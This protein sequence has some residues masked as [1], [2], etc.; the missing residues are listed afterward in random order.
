MLWISI[1]LA[2]VVFLFF[3]AQLTLSSRMAADDFC[4]AEK[5]ADLGFLNRI[6]WW[7]YHYTGRF[8]SQGMALY[9]N[10]LFL[11]DGKA[12]L[13]AIGIMVALWASA[14]WAWN[15]FEFMRPRQGEKSARWLVA[16]LVMLLLAINF[17][18]ASKPAEI[19]FWVAGSCV[20]LAPIVVLL[21]ITG[22]LARGQKT[23]PL[24][25]L[26]VVSSILL[27][28]SSETSIVLGFAGL[29]YMA[30][31]G[32]GARRQLAQLGLVCLLAS[33]AFA[34][35]AP[36]N[37]SRLH[38]ESIKATSSNTPATKSTQVPALTTSSPSNDSM[39]PVAPQATALL[40]LV[41]FKQQWIF[42][43]G[44]IMIAGIALI[45]TSLG[46]APLF[47]EHFPDFPRRFDRAFWSGVPVALVV[48]LVPSVAVFHGIFP[49]RILAPVTFFVS[50]LVGVACLQYA[51]RQLDAGQMRPA[52][53]E[54]IGTGT[55]L[56]LALLFL[57]LIPTQLPSVRT[58]SRIFDSNYVLIKSTP[59]GSVPVLRVPKPGYQ[60]W[61]SVGL[62]EVSPDH[63]ISRCMMRSLDSCPLAQ[64]PDKP[65]K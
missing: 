54:R 49:P 24:L 6:W 26:L 3:W 14:V 51:L 44:G 4:I 60:R 42:L 23:A 8:F 57:A 48:S 11:H 22:V 7:R 1:A 55:T 64:I 59:K 28:G 50:I 65:N 53:F 20:H 33:S 35:S 13:Y 43:L 10:N 16:L 30:L 12:T 21:L 29:G 47:K 58:A 27:G 9:F 56:A 32:V 45:G 41:V 18:L 19:W 63:W 5:V 31:R 25:A 17:A 39:A 37:W 15:S 61:V 34:L 62:P 46:V 52:T 36:G 40:L 2:N 38:S